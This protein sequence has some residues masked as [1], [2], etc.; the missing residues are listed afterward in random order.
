PERVEQLRNR[1]PEPGD[2]GGRALRAAYGA[3]ATRPRGTGKGGRYRQPSP[4][5]RFLDAVRGTD[6][7]ARSFPRSSR[8]HLRRDRRIAGPHGRSG[9]LS[10]AAELVRAGR[11]RAIA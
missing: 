9:V 5:P 3:S 7:N 4:W 2:G 6:A 1:A 11:T 8:D 10:P